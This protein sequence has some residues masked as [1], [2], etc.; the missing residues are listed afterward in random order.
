MTNSSAG[1][2]RRANDRR[3][4][5]GLDAGLVNAIDWNTAALRVTH[6]TQADFAH[7]PHYRAIFIH[8][9]EDLID[10]ARQLLTSGR[11]S[12]QLPLTIAVPKPHG[13]MRPGT[14]LSPIDRLIYQAVVDVLAPHVEKQLDRARTLSHILDQDDD[15]GDMFVSDHESWSRLQKRIQEMAASGGYFVKADIA[16]YFERIPQHALI[17]L[18]SA[19][20]N[21]PPITNL[22]EE[23]LLAFRERDSVGIVQQMYPSDVLGNYFLS[24]LDAHLDIKGIPSARYVDD[25]Y[26]HFPTERA[27][28]AGLADLIARLRKSQL[29]LNE[30]KSGV[31]T[32]KDLLMEETELDLLFA[33]AVEEVEEEQDT[34]DSMYVSDEW[35][36]EEEEEEEETEESP[37][38]PAI[39]RLFESRKHYRRQVDKIDRFCIPFLRAA[40]SPIAVEHC[41][42]GLVSRPYL[43]KLYSGYLARLAQ[44]D[45]RV[46]RKLEALL[47]PGILLYESQRMWV[48][49]ALLYATSLDSK[50][51]ALAVKTLATPSVGQE[52]RAVAAVLAARHGSPAQRREVRTAYQSE[53]SPY[54]RAAILYSAQYFPTA[55]RKT[56][57]RAWGGDGDL[58]PLVCQALATH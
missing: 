13:F 45:P 41:L 8:A 39:T 3:S 33:S 23:M 43:A 10:K 51:A 34:F 14:I 11:Y 9:A 55:E 18:L 53:A 26:L 21:I 54:V 28:Y 57:V 40:A 56:C 6:N 38:I 52:T 37:S 17:N 31:H 12:P 46:G 4:T 35:L 20:P 44:A 19:I 48:M 29:H 32:A 24:D 5:V 15:T 47:Q 27:A 22:L 1:P 16:N 49:A 36:A 7:S 42:A 2:R 25:L 50:T 58:N 30:S